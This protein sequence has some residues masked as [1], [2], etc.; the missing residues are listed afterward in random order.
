MLTD[1][2]AALAQPSKARDRSDGLADVDWQKEVEHSAIG[3]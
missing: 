2:M 3:S 1:F